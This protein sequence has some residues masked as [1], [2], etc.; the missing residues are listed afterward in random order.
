V[1]S[2]EERVRAFRSILIAGG[3]VCTV[4]LS[5]GAP[6][7]A[8]CGMLGE[9]PAANPRGG[10]PILKPPPRLRAAVGLEA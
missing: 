4:R 3:R 8:A 2:D 6:E 10:A 1:G 9:G 5:K 7:A